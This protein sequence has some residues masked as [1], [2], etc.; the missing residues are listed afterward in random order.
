MSREAEHG[1]R[2]AVTLTT[3]RLASQ[4][5]LLASALVLPRFLGADAYGL[6]LAWMA[7][8]AMLRAGTSF[9]LPM[10]EVRFLA[11][12]WRLDRRDEALAL[13]STI[14]M[15]KLVL[16][17]VGGLGVVL[18]FVLS[19]ELVSGPWLVASLALVGVLSFIHE[20]AIS[21]YLPLG[22]VGTLSFFLMARAFLTL[23][24]VLGA[25]A[26]GGLE[27][28]AWALVLLYGALAAAAWVFLHR[29]APF[30]PSRFRWSSLAGHVPFSLAVYVGTVA[31]TVQG[32]FS[33]YAVAAWATVEQAAYL[34]LTL[35]GYGFL[36]TVFF[37][38]KRALTPVLSQIEAEGQ[39]ERLR[40][41]GDVMVRYSVAASVLLILGWTLLGRDVV[42]FALG[43]EFEPVYRSAAIVLICILFSCF[44]E[45]C[46]VLLYI[47]GRARVASTN[48][49]LYA[50]ITVGGVFQALQGDEA[51]TADRVAVAYA[52]AALVYG[53]SSYLTLGFSGRIWL[54]LRRAALLALPAMIVAAT[55]WEAGFYWRVL[56]LSGLLAAYGSAAVGFGLLPADEVVNILRRARRRPDSPSDS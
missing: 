32:Q 55:A 18:W 24:A 45:C 2:Y 51:G 21:L 54:P 33:I 43:H 50:A 29:T 6:Y 13:G 30:T 15:S 5:I 44:A 41:W 25:Y 48:L 39:T 23:V 47:R 8:I 38:A 46:A 42:R 35:Q 53:L 16:A 12:L 36:Q 56:A 20:S 22:R 28:V 9:G 3:G 31:W 40:H 1:I 10:V 7:V 26:W 34:G 27:A 19:P 11:P 37:S 52:V 4:I 14:W 49:L 17:V